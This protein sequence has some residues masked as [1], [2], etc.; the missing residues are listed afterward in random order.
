MAERKEN[1]LL[2]AAL[3]TLGNFFLATMGAFTKLATKDV[4]VPT[5][6]FFQNLICLVLFLPW[7]AKK[8]FSRLKTK[9]IGL[10]LT[11]DVTGLFAFFAL[12]F[13]IKMIPL[14]NA[15]LLN[16]TAPLWIPFVIYTWLRIR[17]KKY[18]WWGMVIGFLGIIFILKPGGDAFQV[19]SFL[20]LAS[21]VLLG[22][23]LVAL[24]RL[25][26]TEPAD[27]IL[28]IYCLFSTFITAPFAISD[29]TSFSPIN[30]LFMLGTGISLMFAQLL[31]SH[32][33]SHGKASILAPIAYTA[34]LFS[35]ILEW[36]I[37]DRIPGLLSIMGM[38]LVIIGGILSIYFEKQNAKKIE[39]I[40][41][42]PR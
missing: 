1:L 23:A 34:V 38:I 36:L 29:W 15:M 42:P 16:N 39:K 5:I 25:A 41:P 4:P 20:G 32:S 7:F 24:R 19:G 3:Y 37:W 9:R 18:L 13:S 11:R 6:L 28:F 30:W 12:F 14:T 27:R 26:V 33:F 21:G 10:H 17:I 8:G 2:G 22:I 31:I 40:N 35:G